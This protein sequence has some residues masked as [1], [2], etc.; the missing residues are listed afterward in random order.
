MSDLSP[1]D[2]IIP[3]LL[4]G[5]YSDVKKAWLPITKHKNCRMERGNTFLKIRSTLPSQSETR[6][7]FA[8][9]L[10]RSLGNQ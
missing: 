6:I 9:I 10:R 1:S 8:T 3:S 7:L 5:A 4:F 2:M